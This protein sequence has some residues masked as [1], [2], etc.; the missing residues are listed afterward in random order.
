MLFR[1]FAVLLLVFAVA[2]NT[3]AK[4]LKDVKQL[5]WQNRV[6]I[7]WSQDIDGTYTDV[8]TEHMAALKDR[9]LIVFVIDETNLRTNF[10]GELTDSFRTSLRERY[11]REKAN[12][13]LLGKDGGL[14]RYG[15]E[16]NAR[17]TF[18]VIDSMPM[19][20]RELDS[21]QY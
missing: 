1:Y 10:E 9:D 14:K 3:N 2:Q 16:F 12:F 15:Q 8:T 17:E 19:R 6:L 18:A 13:F 20:M 11:P 4:S 7:L 5:K 21:E